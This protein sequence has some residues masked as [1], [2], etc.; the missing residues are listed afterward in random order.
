M[1]EMFRAFDKE[2]GEVLWETKLPAG[3]YATPAVYEIEGR[4]YIVIAAGG[5]GK[6]GTRPGDALVAFALSD[7][8]VTTPVA[9][10]GPAPS[11]G[12]PLARGEQLYT[13]RCASCHQY[14]GQGVGGEFPPLVKTDWVTG[15]EERLIRVVL[16]GLSGEITVNGRTYSGAMPPWGGFLDDRQVADLLT[17]LRSSWGNEAPPVSAEEVAAVRQAT[18]GRDRMWTEAELTRKQNH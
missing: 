18:Q 13:S 14:N 9:A 3:G 2:T 11:E 5:G 8:E 1:D 15:D 4:Q 17:F 12:S 10:T 6:P 7:A 16:G